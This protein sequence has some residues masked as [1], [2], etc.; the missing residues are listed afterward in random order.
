MPSTTYA[1]ETHE[2]QPIRRP[3]ARIL[4]ADDHRDVL[5]A[6]RLLLTPEG[7]QLQLVSSA[8]AVLAA[9][10][11][12]DFDVALIEL[13]YAG[14]P[15]AGDG[16]DLLSRIHGIDPTLSVVVMTAWGLVDA[17]L[18]A[19]RRGARD[20]IEKPWDNARLLAILRTQIELS[21][22]L[23][24]GQRLEAENSTLRHFEDMSLDDVECF[25]I[26]KAMTRSEGNVSQSAKALGLSRSALYRRLQRYN[27]S[28]SEVER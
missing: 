3:P 1:V 15:T 12:R 23:R 17:A 28:S 14:E 27:I 11:S 24:R 4:I 16:R 8:A 2:R 5:D 20:F 6:L 9:L 26:R 7:W 13:K 10:R 25:L 21:Q 22:A 18:E 19:M